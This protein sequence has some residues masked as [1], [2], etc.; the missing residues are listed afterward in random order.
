MDLQISD[1][2]RLPA[3]QVKR[4]ER[5]AAI[6]FVDGCPS[7]TVVPRDLEPGRVFT[8]TH[9]GRGNGYFRGY[10]PRNDCPV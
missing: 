4:V 6:S 3:N 10:V 7:M 8:L 9:G 2:C 1:K 5:S